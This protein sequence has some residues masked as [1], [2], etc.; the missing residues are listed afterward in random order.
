MTSTPASRS[1][2]ATTLAPRSCPSR[3]G[4]AMM[5]RMLPIRSA[6]PSR[7]LPPPAGY[8]VPPPRRPRQRSPVYLHGWLGQLLDR[9]I[10]QQQVLD[11]VLLAE[12]NLRLGVV[13]AALNR[14]HPAEA[15]A[16]VVDQVAGLQ[17][18]HR[19]VAWRIHARPARQP[20]R[21][22]A[23]RRSRSRRVPA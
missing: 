4:L 11:A 9:G 2:R 6:P 10:A 1:A 15:V 13:A 20:L 7:R 22:R 23:D 14:E 16:V 12:V 18:R 5:T 8:L 19:P 17:R 21:R 3:P